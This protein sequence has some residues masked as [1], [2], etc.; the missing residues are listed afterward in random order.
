VVLGV[1]VSVFLRETAPRK[2]GVARQQAVV[3]G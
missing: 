1:V 3:A 2:V